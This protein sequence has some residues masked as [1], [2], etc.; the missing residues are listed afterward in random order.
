MQFTVDVDL[1]TLARRYP[2][3]DPKWI[4]EA[5]RRIEIM[6]DWP[7]D[8]GSMQ[9]FDKNGALL[10]S[11]YAYEFGRRPFRPEGELPPLYPG[12]AGRTVKDLTGKER[13][14]GL[15]VSRKSNYYR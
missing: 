13:Y 5:A 8:A 3:N 14:Q 12:A 11:Y 1:A 6:R 2:K 15:G 7:A 4:Q 9:I 10:V